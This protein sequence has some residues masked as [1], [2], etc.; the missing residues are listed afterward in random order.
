MIFTRLGRAIRHWLVA[1]DQLAFVSIFALPYI[2]CGGDA[3]DPQETISSYVGRHAVKGRRSALIAEWLINRLF[4][5]LG[6]RPDHCRR[7][8]VPDAFFLD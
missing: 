2:L 6:G 8:I 1:L 3:P 5:L 7:Y 4:M